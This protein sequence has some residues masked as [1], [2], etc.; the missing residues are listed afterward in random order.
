MADVKG[1]LGIV[2][3]GM[4][5]IGFFSLC[6]LLNGVNSK[7]V[8]RISKASIVIMCVHMLIQGPLESIIHYQGNIIITIVGDIFI[9]LVLTAIYPIVQKYVPVL[10]G[11]RK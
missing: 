6:K 8:L 7:I 1:G 2:A 3:T 5:L 4:G 11:G 10:V 9:V